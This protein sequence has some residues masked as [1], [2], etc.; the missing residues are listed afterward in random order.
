MMIR[1]SSNQENTTIVNI[2][3]PNIRAPTYIEPILINMKVDVDSS[4]ITGFQRPILNEGQII[5]T[6]K[7]IRK[8]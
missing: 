6:E 3:V 4:T 1:G 5:R 2:Y 7:S 8:H